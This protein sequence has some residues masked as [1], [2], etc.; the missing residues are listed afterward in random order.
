M[1]Q[2]EGSAWPCQRHVTPYADWSAFAA[3]CYSGAIATTAGE[4]MFLPAPLRT[5]L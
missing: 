5:A 1:P 3:A 4:D 2:Q